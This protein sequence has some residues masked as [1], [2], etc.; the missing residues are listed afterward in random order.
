MLEAAT[1]A[2]NGQLANLQ[3]EQ[4]TAQQ[5]EQLLEEKYR[6]E[7]T[8]TNRDLQFHLAQVAYLYWQTFSKSHEIKQIRAL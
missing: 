6:S 5:Q 3:L 2:M 7:L 8:L 1:R 4:R